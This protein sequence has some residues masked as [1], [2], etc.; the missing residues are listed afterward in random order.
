MRIASIQVEANDLKNYK[1]AMDKLLCMIEKAAPDHDLILVPEA[2]FPA[3][4]LSPDQ[5]DLSLILE[6][7]ESYLNQIKAIAKR[8]KAYIAYGYV[9]KEADKIYNTAVLL[10]RAGVEI[11]KK[12]KSFLWHFDSKW[13]SVGNEL[14]IAD[15]DFGR[16]ALVICADARMPETIRLA[17]LEGA[18]LII[19]LANL[20]ATGPDISA[21]HN[22]QSAYMLSTR[23]L[24]NQVWLAVSDKWGVEANTITYAG[25]SGVFAPDGQC[26]YQGSSDKDEI[27]S[28]EIPCDEHGKLKKVSVPLTEIRR[29]EYYST[30]TEP[31]ESLPVVKYMEEAV[32]PAQLT[33]FIMA[34]S[35]HFEEEYLQMLRRMVDQGSNLIVLPPNHV[36]IEEYINEIQVMLPPNTYLIAS[37]ID[38]LGETVSYIITNAGIQYVYTTVHQEGNVGQIKPSELIYETKW[39]RVAIMHGT[40]ALVPEWS[41]ILMLQGADCIIWPNQ[42]PVNLSSNI[43]RTRAAENRVFIIS[44]QSSEEGSNISQIIDPNGIVIASTLGSEKY[45]A[46]GT[47]T[48]FIN[49][50]VKEVVPGTNVVKN[51]NPQFYGGALI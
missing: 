17:T 34:A 8:E 7:G 43:A 51:R 23:A 37:T 42:L 38:S 33:P 30:L 9:E 49:S 27:V 26:L 40:E 29:P 50:R 6:D 44:A 16:V 22:A 11:A 3:Y 2:A 39:G 19:D 35:G 13:F 10:N 25:R 31:I 20:T 4:F 14:A 32:V 48:P 15:T 46:C 45:H 36:Q 5:G 21:L 28:V 12:R 41:R 47:L 1:S 18:E 24:E